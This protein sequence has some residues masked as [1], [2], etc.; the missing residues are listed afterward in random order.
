MIVRGFPLERVL[1]LKDSKII[2]ASFSHFHAI[3][4]LL[5]GLTKPLGKIH[6]G[7]EQGKM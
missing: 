2:I 5:A 6:S 3:P 1:N 7:T 4:W